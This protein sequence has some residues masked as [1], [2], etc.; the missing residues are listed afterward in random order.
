MIK[1]R[2]IIASVKCITEDGFT[3]LTGRKGGSNG[4]LH[5]TFRRLVRPQDRT[6]EG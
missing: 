6:E 1:L 3:T 2:S 5:R 4:A